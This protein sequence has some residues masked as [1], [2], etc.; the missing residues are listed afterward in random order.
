MGSLQKIFSTTSGVTV[1]AIL[2]LLLVALYYV[3]TIL[4][5]RPS[6]WLINLAK[7]SVR[8]TGKRINRAEKDYARNLEIGR[9]K[10]KSLT[11]KLYKFLNDL[12]IDLDLKQAGYTPYTCLLYTSP[13]P[14]D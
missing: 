8:V 5:F 7:I 9:Y 10:Q 3:V 2:I 4:K 1:S 11:V 6:E 14:R 12:T 13:S